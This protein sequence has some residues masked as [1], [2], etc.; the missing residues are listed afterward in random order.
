MRQL[1]RD[2][3]HFFRLSAFGATAVL[4]LL[5]AASADP[6][7]CGR[8]VAGLLGVAA[9][10]HAFAYVHNDLCDLAVDRTQPLRAAYPLVRGSVAPQTALAIALACVPTAFA[11]S[12][13]AAA[14]RP[15][16]AAHRHLAAAFG[17]MAAYNYW[18]K[19]CPFPPLTD[20]VQGLG[21]AALLRYGAAATGFPPTRLTG[22]LAS[23]E[24]LLILLVNSVHGG[25]RDLGNDLA[26]G[27]RTT[28]IIFGA[29]ERPDGS[30]AVPPAFLAYALLLQ[31][32]LVA[33]PLWGALAN[34]AGHPT[35]G[36][37]CALVGV[38]AITVL[39]LA[40][41]GAASRGTPRPTEVGMF[42]LMLILTPPLAL[43]APAM[44]P[45]PRAALLLAHT[46]PLLANGMTYAALRWAFDKVSGV[47]F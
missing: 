11:V 34:V 14:D 47:G 26:T 10:F 25:L 43:V 44:A 32:A 45:A 35:K 6:G 40:L 41:P 23:Y 27:A 2:C 18:G 8:R 21:W 17:L 36:Q 42:H 9:A 13:W 31:A 1:A 29:N 39:L 33:L 22:L 38:G 19:R 37:Q 4:P 12:T 7:L 16:S 28:P 24:V 20:L 46:L 3:Y 5:G 30:L 15:R